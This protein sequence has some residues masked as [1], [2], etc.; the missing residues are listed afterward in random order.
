MRKHL[1]LFAVI[2]ILS[3]INPTINTA[4]EKQSTEF[5][6]LT[7]DFYSIGQG[8]DQ[9]AQEEL[10]QFINRIQKRNNAILYYETFSWG[11]EGEETVYIDVRNLKI[12]ERQKFL[13]N[14]YK[15]F[16]DRTKM[17]I[18]HSN[19]YYDAERK[20]L[21]L[22]VSL[23]GQLET[24]ENALLEY[25][26][27]WEKHSRFKINPGSMINETAIAE[28]QDRRNELDLSGLEKGQ[29]TEILNKAQ[30]IMKVSL[31]NILEVDFKGIGG[32]NDRAFKGYLNA[33]IIRFEKENDVKIDFES[34]IYTMKTGGELYTIKLHQLKDDLKK[35]FI[36]GVNKLFAGVDYIMLMYH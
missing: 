31:P 10:F 16:S 14:L 8:V 6:F 25:I 24:R 29:I 27:S 36:D 18:V 23:F 19:L 33:F 9:N 3:A 13:Q 20:Y 17:T 15:L 21:V 30:E 35:K 34:R 7:V 2:I 26:K 5:Y 22:G 28:D 12:E 11:K 32:A 4:Q 1:S